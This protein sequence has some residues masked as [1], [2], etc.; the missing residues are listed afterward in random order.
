MSATTTDPTGLY[1]LP[2][3]EVAYVENN[4]HSGWTII[5]WADRADYDADLARADDANLHFDWHD[6]ATCSI[7]GLD[8]DDVA[9]ELGPGATRADDTDLTL[10]TLS[11]IARALDAAANMHGPLAQEYRARIFNA[12]ES[13]SRASWVDARSV[14][15]GRADWRT[16]WQL[17]A[18][19]VGPPANADR[20]TPTRRQIIDALTRH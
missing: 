17:V 19:H 1:D 6:R 11:A 13:P 12:I 8:R 7:A 16:L 20:F 5:V 18:A 4:E 3:G 2:T 10:E 14:I 15:V 9:A